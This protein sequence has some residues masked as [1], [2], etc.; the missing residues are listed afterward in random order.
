MGSGFDFLKDLRFDGGDASKAES[1]T[2]VD[3]G[4][5]ASGQSEEMVSALKG[6]QAKP[7]AKAK[8]P[9]TISVGSRA[10]VS[11]GMIETL[12]EICRTAGITSASITSGRRSTADQARIMY[13][14]LQSQ[15]VKKQKALYGAGGDAVIA[16]Y[17]AEKKAKK[18]PE[19]IKAAMQAKIE[20]YGATKISKHCSD[21]HDVIDVAPSSISKKKAFVSALATHKSNGDITSYILPPKDPA[22]HIVKS[23]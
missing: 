16:V 18:T 5:S 21:T 10:V 11:A 17:E 8:S 2:A 22:Y 4:Q 1:T 9:V 12:K 7:K 13:N 20:S 23:L 6:T 14:N 3:E 19:Q 15:G